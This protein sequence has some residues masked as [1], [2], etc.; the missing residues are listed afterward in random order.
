MCENEKIFPKKSRFTLC[1]RIIRECIGAVVDIRQANRYDIK[2]KDSAKIRI[3]KQYNVLMHFEALWAMMTIA[4]ETYS[5]P[6]DKKEY[7]SGM[8]LNTEKIVVAWRNSD[9]KRFKEIFGQSYKD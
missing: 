3:A 7:W 2:E 1:D 6:N 8:M 4:L 9:I 5:I